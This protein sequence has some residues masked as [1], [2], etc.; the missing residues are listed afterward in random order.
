MGLDMRYTDV[1]FFAEEMSKLREARQLREHY[2]TCH[3][4]AI[5]GATDWFREQDRLRR[6]EREA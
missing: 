4:D 5:P 3:I 2:L 6:L 1:D